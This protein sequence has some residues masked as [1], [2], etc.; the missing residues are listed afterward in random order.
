MYILSLFSKQCINK[1]ANLL[2]KFST[3]FS[4]KSSNEMHSSPQN[5]RQNAKLP[6]HSLVQLT[7]L[8][9]WFSSANN[10][11]KKIPRDSA[12]ASLQQCITGTIFF[13]IALRTYR[14]LKLGTF[15]VHNNLKKW[16]VKSA[17][18]AEWIILG[19]KQTQTNAFETDCRQQSVNSPKSRGSNS[20]KY[21]SVFSYSL[22]QYSNSFCIALVNFV[23]LSM[24]F[25]FL[26]SFVFTD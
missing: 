16:K 13:K 10:S 15:K 18:L 25:L 23:S 5:L 9:Q 3:I 14:M 12:S 20:D 22:V 26:A 21:F 4:V 2:P 24:S 17:S 6:A 19:Y 1:V 11:E 8:D 7:R